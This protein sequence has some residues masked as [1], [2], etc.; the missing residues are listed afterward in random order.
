[1]AKKFSGVDTKPWKLM[2]GNKVVEHK[3]VKQDSFKGFAD[4]RDASVALG[5][6]P[7]RT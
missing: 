1:M 5:G 2:K 4:A 6:V 3:G 7:V